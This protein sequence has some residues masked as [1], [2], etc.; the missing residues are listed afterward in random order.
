MKI[1]ITGASGLIG[2]R[3]LTTLASQGHSPYALSRH[4][5]TEEALREADAVV[6]L[7]GESVAQ[8]W[9]ADAKRRILESREAGTRSLVRT[10][11]KLP[12]RPGVL[13]CASAVGYYG[14][15]GDETLTEASAPGTGFLP[16]V[17]VAWE[18]EAQAAEAL[19]IRVVR[20]RIGMALD[21]RGGALKSI[22]P[23]F[24]M[25][26]GGKL[27]DGRQWMSWIHLDDLAALFRFALENPV[28]GPVNAVAPQPVTNADFT[29][30]LARALRRPALCPRAQAGPAPPVWRDVRDPAGQPARR[31][32]S[33][34]GGRVWVPLPGVGAGAGGPS[35][36]LSEIDFGES[37]ARKHFGC[38]MS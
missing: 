3:L 36:S 10:L 17:C 9:T 18:R 23:V 24:R 38:E 22:L 4:A 13:V 27:G 32:A 19:G 35:R 12:R 34:R 37:L 16:E 6:H 7:A 8:R 2:R 15:R 30:A 26:A 14:S 33:R 28:A 1:A 21:R 31:S 5:Y 25:G 29:R 11:A 20:M